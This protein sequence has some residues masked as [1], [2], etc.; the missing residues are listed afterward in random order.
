M[1]PFGFLS[2]PLWN[3]LKLATAF[4]RGNQPP[5]GLARPIFANAWP[6]AYQLA[7]YA[8][9]A[10][11]CTV[12]IGW[13]QGAVHLGRALLAAFLTGSTGAF[14]W[15][16]NDDLMTSIDQAVTLTISF[17]MLQEPQFSTPIFPYLGS[18]FGPFLV[19]LFIYW[20]PYIALLA[21]KAIAVWVGR[22]V[23]GALI[24]IAIGLLGIGETGRTIFRYSFTAWLCCFIIGPLGIA[25]A[26]RLSQDATTHVSDQVG[27]VIVSVATVLG[28]LAIMW[29][30]VS[31]A[32]RVNTWISKG[33]VNARVEGD[34]NSNIVNDPNVTASTIEPVTTTEP[35]IEVSVSPESLTSGDIEVSDYALRSGGVVIGRTASPDE[36]EAPVTEKP[37]PRDPVEAYRRSMAEAGY[38]EYAD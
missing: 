1:D 17:K 35:S 8:L 14:V 38:Q 9:V 18:G 37:P 23:V 29:G 28:V 2:E 19:Y 3:G 34:T 10:L 36:L 21:V 26:M 27:A 22:E 32:K 24:I 6:L 13:I 20:P 5:L 25:V 31:L 11:L 33:R 7:V 15:Y 30:L 4:L 16:V 12:A